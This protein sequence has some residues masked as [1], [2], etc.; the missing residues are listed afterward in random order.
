MLPLP[1]AEGTSTSVKALPAVDPVQAL[2]LVSGVLAG[3]TWG[4]SAPIR[5]E[6]E[7]HGLT[8]G[9]D[10]IQIVAK[11]K[12]PDRDGYLDGPLLVGCYRELYPDQVTRKSVL[13][14]V[15]ELIEELYLHEFREAF[16]LDGIRLWDPHAVCGV[17]PPGADK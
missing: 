1:V 6:F 3:I 17:S 15:R 5:I 13:Y 16:L 11:V 10:T 4:P 8:D 9:V 12:V 7:A 2:E 14:I